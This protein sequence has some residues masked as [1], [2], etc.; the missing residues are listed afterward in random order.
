[1]E[2]PK[3]AR[4]TFGPGRWREAGT[5]DLTP[6]LRGALSAFREQGYHGTSVR[7]IATRVGVTVPALYYHHGSKQGMLVGLLDLA[8]DELLLRLQ[9]AIAEAGDSP[10]DRYRNIVQA[11]IFHVTYHQDLATLDDEI[12]SLEPENRAHYSA[13]RAQAE[14]SLREAIEDGVRTGVFATE[15]VADTARA[16]LGMVSSIRNWYTPDGPLTP[17]QIADRYA[18][19]ALDAV[20]ASVD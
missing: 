11:I 14:R 6:T 16:I 3:T 18:N 4:R 1:V 17:P 10:V 19:I 12:R 2:R 13:L 15:H 8:M 5:P 20:N 7:D 9:F